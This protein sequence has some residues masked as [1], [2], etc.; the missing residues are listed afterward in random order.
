MTR[1]D[2]VDWVM[3]QGCEIEEFPDINNTA[4][5][6]KFVNPKFKGIAYAYID[7]PF[8]T[9]PV[10]DFVVCHI[11]HNLL[12]IKVPDEVSSQQALVE[13]LRDKFSKKNTG[14]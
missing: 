14:K 2:L 7:S 9:R 3:A 11:C 13:H 4:Y 10:T 6:V 12:R 8:D 5:Q 1:A